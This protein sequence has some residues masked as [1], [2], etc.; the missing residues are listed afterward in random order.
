MEEAMT[1]P[2]NWTL[3]YDWGCGGNYGST[4]MTVAAGGTW[5]NGQGYN[6]QWVAAAGMITFQ[7]NGSKTTYSGNLASKSVTGIM[8]TFSGTNGCFYMLQAGA[9]T[10]EH[11]KGKLDADG[12]QS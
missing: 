1:F 11:V 6:G 8:S 10:V 7:F 3:Y 2:G 9:A 4:P 12:K 5:T